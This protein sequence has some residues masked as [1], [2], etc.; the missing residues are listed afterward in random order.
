MDRISRSSH[1]PVERSVDEIFKE[2]EK[3]K[4][5]N[6][7]YSLDGQVTVEN[8]PKPLTVIEKWKE[9]EFD[10]IIM[11]NIQLVRTSQLICGRDQSAS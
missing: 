10:K 2:D 6:D 8:S 1:I 5:T 4:Q 11:N 9:A 7:F 3:H